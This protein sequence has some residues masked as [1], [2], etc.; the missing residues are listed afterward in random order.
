MRG[1]TRR[2][3]R[4]DLSTLGPNYQAI[5]GNPLAKFCFGAVLIE[6]AVLFGLLPYIA[7]L[8]HQAGETR[9]TIA[10]LVIAGYGIGGVIYTFSVSLLLRHVGERRLMWSG[11]ILMALCLIIVGV[12][13]SWQVQFVTLLV[14]G[15]SF[16]M[17]HGSIQVFVTELAP[18]ARGSAAALH[19]AFFFFGQA[20][21]PICYGI[22]F[23]K[24]GTAASLSIGA[25]LLAVTGIV[26]ARSLRHRP[27]V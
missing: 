15:F 9:A 7:T 4:V 22:G 25:L 16:Y 12:R 17:L 23:A 20:L 18:Q 26:C 13:P 3:S 2:P 27:A 24:I 5:F 11:G 10:G 21:G 19:S 8:L 14:L 6:G 1:V